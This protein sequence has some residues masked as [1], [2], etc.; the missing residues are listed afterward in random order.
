MPIGLSQSEIGNELDKPET[1]MNE[2]YKVPGEADLRS[3]L[4]A[5]LLAK[6]AKEPD[7]VVCEELGI[8]RGHVRVD[9]AIVNGILHG[10]EIKSDRDSLRR[11]S[12][13][14]DYYGRVFD[15]AT[16]VVGERH[17][18]D[19]LDRLPEWWGVMSAYPASGSLRFKT[20]RPGRRNP[21]KD[22]RSLV[23]LLWL[24][25]ALALLESRSVVRGAR[26]KPR[27]LIWDRICEHFNIHEITEAVLCQLKA[28]ATPKDPA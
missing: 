19:A 15:R 20:V 3:A 21:A 10:Y 17:M 23:E 16:L 9:L 4:K 27:Q 7:T 13:Q 1:V 24:K 18:S 25:D 11:L 2:E 22:P 12:R 8:C 14:V 26:G 5:I 6:H 28:R